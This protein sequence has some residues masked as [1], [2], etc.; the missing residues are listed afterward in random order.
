LAGEA[1][2]PHPA[3]LV[4]PAGVGV[5]AAVRP[6]PPD[7]KPIYG[8]PIGPRVDTANF[9]VQWVEGQAT[10]A[11]GAAAAAALEEAWAALVA[12]GGWPGPVSSDTYLLWV[13]LDP[14][15]GGTGFTT[16][17]FT[18]E[19]PGGYPVM[20]L[21]P[22]WADN[23]DFWASLAAHEF[24]HAVQFGMRAWAG[25]GAES[26]YWE[27]S[28][29][30]AAERAVPPRDTY[31]WSSE[32]F[33]SQP[34]LRYDSMEN[35]HQYGMF[36]VNAYA[37]E[38]LDPEAMRGAWEAGAAAPGADWA[39]LLSGVVGA[40]PEALW[41][42]AAAAYAAGALR[43]SR[44]YA[45][46][47]EMGALAEGAAGT[48]PRLGVHAWAVEADARVEAEGPVWL[49]GPAGVGPAVEVLAGETLVV[50]GAADDAAYTLRV[51][52]PGGG[53]DTG[54]VGGD[55]GGGGGDG[56]AGAPGGD[57]KAAGAGCA[58]AGSAASAVLAALAALGVSGR[59]RRRAG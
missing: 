41:A 32:W 36:F 45:P 25:T 48:L 23:G 55:A 49:G 44:L 42:E 29:E 20:Y 7:S 28:A 1:P 24:A 5:A 10:E 8:G 22:T 16:V 50:V 3:A 39:A 43:E 53:A 56:L 2:A 6:A 34:Q 26:W 54:G 27:A 18:D 52:P 47:A 4:A 46:I 14:S 58:G 35:Y 19:Y 13:I 40:A 9:T 51:G 30:W 11:Q 57:D 31:A 15:L 38:A 17:Y 37:E 12:E 21:N 59:R 33:G